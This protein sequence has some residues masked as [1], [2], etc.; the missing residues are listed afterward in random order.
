MQA[1][2]KFLEKIQNSDEAAKKRWVAG[3]SALAM[4]M[5]IFFWAFT[6]NPLAD[7]TSRLRG[8]AGPGFWEI[9]TSGLREVTASIKNELKNL[10]STLIEERSITIEK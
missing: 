8:E 10:S 7:S 2:K 3:A 6:M 4:I 1:I 9:F 5:I